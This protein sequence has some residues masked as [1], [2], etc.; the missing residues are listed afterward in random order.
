M[1]KTCLRSFGLRSRT[2]IVLIALIATACSESSIVEPGPGNAADDTTTTTEAQDGSDDDDG[3][4]G[5]VE[6]ADE[7]PSTTVDSDGGEQSSDAP[8]D[9]VSSAAADSTA[10]TVVIDETSENAEAFTEL[11]ASGLVLTLDEQGCADGAALDAANGGADPVDAVVEAVQSCASP[12]AIDD[13]A[14]GLIEA[15]GA[16]LPATEAA[17]VS[18]QLQATEE[19]RPFWRA[20]LDDEPFDFL[21]SETEVQ[22]RYLD[23]FSECVSVGRAVADQANITL[24]APT[25]GC[26]DTLYNDRE[27]VRVTILADLSGDPEERA[28]IDSQIAGCFT[29]A[30]LALVQ[31]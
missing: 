17:C 2:A 13:F 9:V 4:D 21:L 25:Q 14:S 28:R 31:G 12:A 27:F 24:S 8:E 30:E 29:S 1:L 5:D 15:G 26:I 11:A 23:L 7:S 6:T 3:G 18:S 20:L 19:Y 10:T 22:N 16:P